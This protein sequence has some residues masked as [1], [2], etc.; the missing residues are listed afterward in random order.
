MGF[1]LLR[2]VRPSEWTASRPH[3][4]GGGGHTKVG[5]HFGLLLLPRPIDRYRFLGRTEDEFQGKM[6][7]RYAL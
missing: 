2:R 3:G 1:H 4:G 7:K 6:P 5:R